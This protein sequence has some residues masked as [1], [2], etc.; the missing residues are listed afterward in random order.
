M[1]RLRTLVESELYGSDSILGMFLAVVLTSCCLAIGF[2]SVYF[3]LI[4]FVVLVAAWVYLDV[5]ILYYLLIIGI[6]ISTE[7]Y[8]PNGLGTD[9]P[10]EQCMWLL[11]VIGLFLFMTNWSRIKAIYILHPI[12]LC[13]M[14]MLAWLLITTITSQ[15][16]VQSTKYLLAK[17]WYV[18]S[19]FGMS[20][21]FLKTQKQI[22]RVFAILFSVL[23]S[24]VFIVVLRHSS[25]GFSFESINSMLYPFYRNHVNYACLLAICV[26]YLLW[27]VR[28]DRSSFSRKGLYFLFGVLLIGLFFSY[29]RAAIGAAFLLPVFYF[30]V[31]RRWVRQVSIAS[32][33]A[34]LLGVG[35][36][37]SNRNYQ[38]FAPEFAKTIYHDSFEDILS[39]TYKFEDL[40][41]MERVYR[42]VAGYHMIQDRPLVGVGAANFF[43]SYKQYTVSS[44]TTYVSDNEDGSGI[45]NYYLMIAVEQGLPALI[46]FIVTILC[47]LLIGERLYHTLI[48]PFEKQLILASMGSFFIILVISVMNDMLETDKVGTIYFISLAFLVR[49]SVLLEQQKNASKTEL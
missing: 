17:I 6:P 19:M 31:N 20:L 30:I 38:A 46:I 18:V 48:D 45:H 32:L 23:L 13:V 37:V 11:T 16:I 15:D 5:R 22:K 26:P 28:L 2:Q 27:Y 1:K 41:T 42:W 49:G 29:T 4:P 33:V 25:T 9:V 8:L 12:S 7:V 34:V 3:L 43:Q 24:T 39:A 21:Y 47:F 10:I 44:F 36:L 35:A 40:S 14:A